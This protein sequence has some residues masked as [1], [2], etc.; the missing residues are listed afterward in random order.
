MSDSTITPATQPSSSVKSHSE[1]KR[2]IILA[3]FL[4]VALI[5]A[6]LWWH[7]YN[8]YI[9]T[10]DANLDSYRIDIAP[11]V[12]GQI[13]RLYVAEG[14][15]VKKG[16]PLFDLDK[17]AVVSRML[18]A[19]AQYRQLIAQLEV[20]KTNL[21]ELKNN[22]KIA[23]LNENLSRVN[24]ERSQKQ[25][26]GEATTLEAFQ[27][28]EEAYKTACLQKEIAKNRIQSANAQIEATQMSAEA[29]KANV[30]TMNTDLGYYQVKAPADGII[31]KRWALAGDIIN[32]G[33]TVFT[34]NKNEK[35]WVSVYLEETKFSNI[36]MGQKAK[37]TL[38]AYDKLTLYGTIYYIGDNSASEF[39]LVPPNNASGNYTKVTQRIPLKI[40]IDRIEGNEQ[41]KVKMKLVSG[42]S[43]TVKIEKNK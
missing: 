19:E 40:S 23:E 28:M 12:N 41:Q 18:Q 13:T 15:S 11:M 10:D 31:G 42:M 36:F 21:S 9:S 33:Q 16:E 1:K 38:D 25:L 37:I 2:F 4:V 6:F 34:L 39:A 20:S 30:E 29:A 7:N 26:A 14:D 22:L 43:A 3:I 5:G 35:I 32:A 8:K 17:E 24:Y 27:N